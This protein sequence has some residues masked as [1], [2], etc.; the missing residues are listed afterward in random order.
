M[1]GDTSGGLLLDEWSVVASLSEQRCHL[2]VIRKNRY[3]TGHRM[4]KGIA[5]CVSN[6]S[7]HPSARKHYYVDL[8]DIND[9]VIVHSVHISICVINFSTNQLHSIEYIITLKT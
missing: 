2:D 7:K 1:F 3:R 9:F 8:S 5:L 4:N 6:T